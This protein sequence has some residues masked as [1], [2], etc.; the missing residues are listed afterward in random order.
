MT[1]PFQT[2]ARREL[3]TRLIIIMGNISS[4]SQPKINSILE[5]E[6][7]QHTKQLRS[8]IN[9]VFCIS[10]FIKL[11]D[12]TT[13]AS[14]L[15]KQQFNDIFFCYSSHFCRYVATHFFIEKINFQAKI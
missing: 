6:Q 10:Y 1:R 4:Y 2:G 8:L 13:T 14:I 15:D 11:E 3:G 9:F 7:G 12:L 5:T